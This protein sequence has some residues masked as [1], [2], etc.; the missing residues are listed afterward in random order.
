MKLPWPRR[1]LHLDLLEMMAVNVSGPRCVHGSVTA[2]Y[3][4]H[5]DR[6]RRRRHCAA[7][8]PHCGFDSRPLR[9]SLVVV[10]LHP[11]HAGHLA[12]DGLVATVLQAV[13]HQ[14]VEQDALEQCAGPP[15][16]CHPAG[17][18]L[19]LVVDRPYRDDL[20]FCLVNSIL[21]LSP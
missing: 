5:C 11:D 6:R 19:R 3:R 18:S 2:M 20:C 7:D 9:V 15:G 10:P 13:H 17:V 14:L 4:R 1:E 12:E 21:Q 8:G 16:A